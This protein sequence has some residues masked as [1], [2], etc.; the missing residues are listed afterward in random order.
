[1]SG[2]LPGH[3]GRPRYSEQA[4]DRVDSAIAALGDVHATGEQLRMLE[5]VFAFLL[6]AQEAMQRAS[7][8]DQAA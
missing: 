7:G 1:M 4:A 8:C 6:E 3:G 2:P 5:S